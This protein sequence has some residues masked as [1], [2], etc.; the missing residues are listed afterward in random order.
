MPLTPTADARASRAVNRRKHARKE[1]SQLTFI[2]LGRDNGGLL[3]D[4]SEGGLG[5]EGILR[6]SDGEVLSLEFKLPSTNSFIRGTG[7]FVRSNESSRGGGLRFVNLSEEDRRQ[8]RQWIAQEAHQDGFSDGLRNEAAPVPDTATAE[9]IQP[10]QPAAAKQEEQQPEHVAPSLAEFSA[11]AFSVLSPVI[12]TPALEPVAE[13]RE[14][15][16]AEMPTSSETNSDAAKPHVTPSAEAAKPTPA[17]SKPLQQTLPPSVQ[18]MSNGHQETAKPHVPPVAPA[19]KPAAEKF[20]ALPEL[21]LPRID[22][23]TPAHSMPNVP[24]AA[25]AVLKS[26]NGSGAVHQK[27]EAVRAAE[28]AAFTSATVTGPGSQALLFAGGVAAGCLTVVL[29]GSALFVT[30]HLDIPFLTGLESSAKS[31]AVS[32]SN[33]VFQVDVMN[34][35]NRRWVMQMA[36]GTSPPPAQARV[37]PAPASAAAPATAPA[38]AAATPGRLA[39]GPPRPVKTGSNYSPM[40]LQEPHV[41]TQAPT[42]AEPQAPSV[43]EGTTP[44]PPVAD[45][46]AAGPVASIPEAVVP[47]APRPE[48]VRQPFAT[49]VIQPETQPAGGRPPSAVT[50]FPTLQPEQVRPTTQPDTRRSASPNTVFPGPEPEAAPRPSPTTFQAA[51]LVERTE[52]AYPPDAR[53]RGIRGS[54]KINATIGKDGVPRKMKAVSGDARLVS[55]AIDAIGHWRYQPATLDGQPIESDASITINFQF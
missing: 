33:A 23:K 2:D 16:R 54:V 28:K 41:A 12:L 26:A 47:S 34:L 5:F 3:I 17:E 43:A 10:P 38:Q 14:G 39:A 32:S 20:K 7:Q 11:D 36:P 6:L 50:V 22:F 55:A 18:A 21:A 4:V 9:T 49:A 15:I 24:P 13:A 51:T 35:N 44:P 27:Q 1:P 46:R 40:A 31:E 30:G 8:I 48:T 25:P 19:P 29:V 53:L 45:S 52:P 37:S 42:P